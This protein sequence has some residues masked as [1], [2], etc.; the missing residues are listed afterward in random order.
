VESRQQLAVADHGAVKHS[1]KLQDPG[2][3]GGGARCAFE[4]ADFSLSQQ[5]RM[6]TAGQG[7]FDCIRVGGVVSCRV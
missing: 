2:G 3:F 1:E 5:A 7:T 6:I 4:L